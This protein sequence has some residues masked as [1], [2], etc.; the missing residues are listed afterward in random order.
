[1]L[2]ILQARREWSEMFCVLKKYKSRIL[3]NEIIIQK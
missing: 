2:E 3:S 1:M